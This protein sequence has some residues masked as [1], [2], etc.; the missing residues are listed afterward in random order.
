MA[1]KGFGT[2]PAI[3]VCYDRRQPDSSE[4][5]QGKMELG[6]RKAV[7]ELKHIRTQSRLLA[8]VQQQSE[9]ATAL[10]IVAK[11]SDEVLRAAK[12]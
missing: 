2:A 11:A 8:L 6:K 5:F 10:D 9:M 3:V 1:S 4:R 12:T 7:V